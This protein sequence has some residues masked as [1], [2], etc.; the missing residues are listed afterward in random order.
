[1]SRLEPRVGDGE[2]DARAERGAQRSDFV[3]YAAQYVDEQQRLRSFTD[4]GY[5]RNLAQRFA[6]A[7]WYLSLTADCNAIICYASGEVIYD[8]WQL[9][10]YPF[11]S[12]AR[13]HPAC[14][15]VQVYMNHLN[16]AV[17]GQNVANPALNLD[18]PGAAAPAQQFGTQLESQG[19]EAAGGQGPSEVLVRLR[20]MDYRDEDVLPLLGQAQ[21]HPGMTTDWQVSYIVEQLLRVQQLQQQQPQQTQNLHPPGAAA[22]AQQLPDNIEPYRGVIVEFDERERMVDRNVA[23]QFLIHS[24]ILRA[25]AE[26]IINNAPEDDDTFFDHV[27]DQSG[28]KLRRLR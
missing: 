11:G 9:L 5:N 19:N 24:G 6:G 14:S 8:G 4:A 25:D 28:I 26:W 16:Q 27:E 21:E 10:T 15:F 3:P 1:V 17:G 7:G 12:H 2:R 13:V 20:D 23:H 22:P 18:P